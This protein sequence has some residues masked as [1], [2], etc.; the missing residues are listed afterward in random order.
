MEVKQL[1]S[2][3][4]STLEEETVNTLDYFP[5]QSSFT[6]ALVGARDEKESISFP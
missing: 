3:G 2:F 4:V 6:P 5:K 1:S